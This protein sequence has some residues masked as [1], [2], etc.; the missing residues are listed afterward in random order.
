MDL[1]RFE[2]SLQESVC[3]MRA[4]LQAD[5]DDMLEKREYPVPSIHMC[6]ASL[7]DC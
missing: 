7:G 2:S 4:A 6:E 5:A 3:H 1:P